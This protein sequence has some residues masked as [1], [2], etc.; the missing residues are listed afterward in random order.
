MQTHLNDRRVNCSVGLALPA[1]TPS[2]H[3]VGVGLSSVGS[4]SIETLMKRSLYGGR[5]A[6]R[7]SKRLWAAGFIPPPTPFL[8]GC[9]IPMWGVVWR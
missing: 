2:S 5:K 4:A 6:R 1:P 9:P 7:A 3:R 8:I